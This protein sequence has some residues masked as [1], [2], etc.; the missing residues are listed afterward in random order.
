MKLLRLQAQ[1]QTEHFYWQYFDYKWRER[2]HGI[3][4]CDVTVFPNFI[5]V[6]VNSRQNPVQRVTVGSFVPNEPAKPQKVLNCRYF[7]GKSC[8]T[9]SIVVNIAD[10]PLDRAR[11]RDS[12]LE[13][14]WLCW[15]FGSYLALVML[16]T[17]NYG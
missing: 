13:E 5:P 17:C 1:K 16:H 8:E 11:Q 6:M 14:V 12:S 10:I 2:W 4:A 15:E 3:T 7:C 9:R